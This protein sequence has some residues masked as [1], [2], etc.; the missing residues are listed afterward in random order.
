MT[1]IPFPVGEGLCTRF[2]TQIVSRRERHW[3]ETRI[4][5][6]I[7]ASGSV[8]PPQFDPLKLSELT[9]ER[10]RDIITKVSQMLLSLLFLSICSC[11]NRS[12]FGIQTST[13]LGVSHPSQKGPP[14]AGGK[15]FSTDMLNIEISGPTCSQYKLVDLP[16]IFH[17]GTSNQTSDDIVEVRKMI[18]EHMK[19][20]N[21]FIV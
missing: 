20:R 3:K 14:K 18:Q 12:F 13:F 9:E 1:G 8:K 10:F 4:K 21:T 6:S 19:D 16:G 7:D 17:T 5:I 2:A 11:P 15:N